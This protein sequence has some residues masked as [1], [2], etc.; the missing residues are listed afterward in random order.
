MIAAA[1]LRR[2]RAGM[3]GGWDMNADSGLPIMETSGGPEGP[4]L[5]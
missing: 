4:P 3:V 5:R 1:G 2:F